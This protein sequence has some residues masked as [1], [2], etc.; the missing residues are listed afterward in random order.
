MTEVSPNTVQRTPFGW[1]LN[2]PAAAP[3]GCL[4]AVTAKWCGHCSNLKKNVSKAQSFA[5]F[6]AFYLDGDASDANRQKAEEMGIEGFPTVYYVG[7]DGI[8]KP[9][10]GPTDPQSLGRTFHK[11]YNTYRGGGGGPFD[12]VLS[13]FR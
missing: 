2:H 10:Q 7:R 6:D 1:K 13:W 9:H 8:L 11:G 12:G 5:P 3:G 4:F